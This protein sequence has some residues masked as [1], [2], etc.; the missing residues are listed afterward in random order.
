MSLCYLAG[1]GG[2]GIIQPLIQ[3]FYR[4][5]I[6]QAIAI[7]Q[8][9]IV[10]FTVFRFITQI[11]KKHPEKRFLVLVDYGMASVMMPATLAGTQIGTQIILK[12]FPGLV[13]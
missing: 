7:A 1:I 13:I 9:T 11:F 2:G 12:T 10:C 8:F 4:F 3:A 5:P 6:K